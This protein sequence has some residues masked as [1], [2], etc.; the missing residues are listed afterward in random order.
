MSYKTQE[1]KKGIQ[2]HVIETNKFKTNLFAMFL[3][4]PLNRENI[5]QNALIPAVLRRGTETLKSQEEISIEL[6]NMYG[7][8]LDCGVEKTG[9]NQVLKFYL[10]TLND[11]F[12]PNKEN[13][14]KKAIELLLDVIFNPLTE[15]NHFKKEYVDSEKK[16]IKRLIDGRIDN[17]DMYAY[18]RCIE[19]MYKNE[20]YGL[21]KY[22]YIEDLENINE[23]NLYTDYQNLL[24][25]AKI[26][27]FASGE[28]Q[29]D[30]VISIIE[31]NQNIQKLQEREDTHIVNT[32]DT[33]KKKEVQIQTIQDVKDVTQGKLVIGLDID[34]YK[35]DSR[36]AMCIYNVILGESATSKMFQNVR[37]KAGLAY[38]A[39][40]TYI[41]QKNN[42]FIRAG[43]EIKN[44]SKA[45]EIIKEQLED[46]KNGKF[47][48]EEIDNA[49]KYMT[50]GIKTVQDEQDS[51]I[52]YY[53]G[54]ELSKTLLT[55]EEYMDKINSVTREE[56]LEIA[57]NIH[58]NT[59]YFLMNENN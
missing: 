14:S 6:E 58:I 22:G 44:Y 15:N 49:K 11:N 39:R 48:D 20:P 26:D 41:R 46:M 19:E 57:K 28:L 7:A 34:Y 10:E 32:E 4:V 35:K 16:T 25:I 55:F 2:A 18:T 9:D 53:M 12:L 31:G 21:Y 1:I 33:E 24:S 52:T 3:T 17:K 47:S 38:S 13:L 29:T 27:F 8:T 43:I 42:I 54:Q 5:T 40:S 30:S 23:E 56:I 36:Y 51:E 45:L 50:S 37:E 59:I